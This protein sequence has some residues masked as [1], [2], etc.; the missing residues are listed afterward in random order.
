M[1]GMSKPH[2][3]FADLS[4]SSTLVTSSR[5][6]AG[7]P[8]RE[9][10]NGAKGTFKRSLSPNNLWIGLIIEVWLFTGNVCG[11]VEYEMQFILTTL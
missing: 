10:V 1:N 8:I 9:A 7:P 4:K 6:S 2:K 11:M 3:S 5:A